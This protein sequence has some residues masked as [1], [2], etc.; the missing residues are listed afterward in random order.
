[1]RQSKQATGR[2]YCAEECFDL[3]HAEGKVMASAKGLIG[4]PTDGQTRWT[5]AAGYV[6]I[7]VYPEDRPPGFEKRTCF[8]EHRII[9]SKMIGRHLDSYETVHHKNG[10]KIDNRPENLELWSGKHLRGERVS[11]QL[12]WAREIIAKYG[13]VEDKIT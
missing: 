3:D 8:P 2:L 7:Y 13:P 1:M 11:D 10:D 9:M 12:A 4:R 6:Q 5:D